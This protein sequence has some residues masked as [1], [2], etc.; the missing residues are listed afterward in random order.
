MGFYRHVKF[1][2]I[3]V[4]HFLAI[5]L[6]FFYLYY[7]LW[8]FISAAIS[9]NYV[10]FQTCSYMVYSFLFLFLPVVFMW[11]PP[12]WLNKR[13]LIRIL[14]FAF[15]LVMVVGSVADLIKYKAFIG[16][17]FTEGDA[18]FV[19]L[20]M[21][22]PNIWGVV[23]CII[24]AVLYFVVG[25]NIAENPPVACLSYGLIFVIDAIIPVLWAICI[26][27]TLPRLTWIQKSMYLL[28]IQLFLLISMILALHPHRFW[29]K[30]VG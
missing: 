14:C 28:P 30:I 29:W 16:Y 19:N 18:I 6:W 25:L 13:L 27:N 20:I 8:P 1:I 9:L 5:A 11:S 7:S 24:L 10:N 15:A 26:G 12:K 3:S 21:N 17:T 4:L 23:F 2:S 22:L